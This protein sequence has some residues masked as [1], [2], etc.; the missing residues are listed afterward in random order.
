[1]INIKTPQEIKI[2]HKGGKILSEVMAQILKNI[3]AG[4][5]ELEIDALA[6]NLIKEKGAEPG[7]KK[8]DGYNHAICISTNDVSVHGI[9]AG[10]KFKK[11]DVVGVDCGV[12]YQGFHTDMS[13]TVK[14]SN[15]ILNI[16]NKKDEVDKFLETGK[17]ALS[18]AIN[19]AKIGNN[20][21]DISKTIQEIVEGSGYSVVRT[22]VGHGVGKQLHE[23]P[24][25]PGFLSE[26]IEKTPKLAQ[27]M[28]IAIEVIYNMGKPDLKLD[29]DGWTL[30][31]EDG[32]LAG[33]YERTVAITKNG[34][35]ILTP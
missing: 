35:L 19:Q 1:M 23:D 4:V 34:P 17:K 21:G 22:L 6:E 12:Y 24:E 25:V 18:E 16:K 31:T 15:K 30:R 20:I 9:P 14:V 13:E 5:S 27:G 32:S 3:N 28:V 7:F 33:L 8:V 11:G 2:M 29:K 26:P 10:Y